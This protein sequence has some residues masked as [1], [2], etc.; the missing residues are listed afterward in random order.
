MYTP[1]PRAAQHKVECEYD[2]WNV[3]IA[4]IMMQL[5]AMQLGAANRWGNSPAEIWN[6]EMQSV[7]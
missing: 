5:G 3:G 7:N 6:V 1:P 4:N 2:C